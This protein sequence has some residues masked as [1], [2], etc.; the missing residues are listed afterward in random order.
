L[1]LRRILL[2]AFL[3]LGLLP[4]AVLSWLGFVRAREALTQQISQSLDAQ[5]RSLQTE[6]DAMMFERVENAL[7]WSR[8]E[9]MQDL[10]LGDV[11]KRVANYLVGLHA[12]YGDVYARL[13]CLDENG[14]AVAS[15]DARRIGH[16]AAPAE[17]GTLS[18]EARL[19]GGTARLY[20]PASTPILIE[21][22]IPLAFER[23]GASAMRLR[24]EVN[25]AQ[26][27]RLLD[28]GAVGQRAVVVVDAHGRWIAASAALRRRARPTQAAQHAVREVAG[29][30]AQHVTAD[31]TWLPVASLVGRGHSQ[32]TPGFAGTGWT[33]LVLQPAE[34]ALQPVS[35]MASIFAGLLAAVLLAT[36]V[37]ASRLSSAIA[38]PID[39]LTGITLAYRATGHI[40]PQRPAGSRITEVDMLGKAY[41]D[42]MQAV[43]HSRQ[44]LVRNSKMAMLGELAA[45][46]AHEV[47]TPLGILR[48]SAQVLMR[49]ANLGVD[50]RELMSF[51]ES[52]TLRLNS[53]VSSMLATARPRQPVLAPCDVHALLARCAQMHDLQRIA[54]GGS[55]APIELALEAQDPWIDVDAEQ[56]VQ[57]CFNLL[58]NAA[59]ACGPGGRLQLSTRE[60]GAD[61]CI[62]CADDGPGIAPEL[63]ERIF[64]P[65]VSGREGGIGLGLAVVRQIAGAHG[66][67]ITVAR[68][69]WGGAAFTLRLPRHGAARPLDGRTT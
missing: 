35:D 17:P 55:R 16:I 46:L 66:G 24:L 25:P 44:E 27:E 2:L 29:S 61:L 64:D 1:T 68:A 52:E 42:M 47:R 15:S 37:V 38:H 34:E 40:P 32:A 10:R 62:T 60:D 57:A 67:S 43:Q 36:V 39:T 31:P 19:A 26:V 49:D 30:D 5:A 14:L 45:V 8:S 54:A 50:G 7:V 21:T 22:P 9:L 3:L 56:L 48:S 18:L 13:E 41:V 23:P 28:A 12:G 69:A 6:V 33:T 51:I 65:F 4:S 59:Q 53:L 11:D 63:A 20:A 58:N